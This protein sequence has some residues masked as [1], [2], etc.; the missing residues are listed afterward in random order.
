MMLIILF[1]SVILAG[2]ISEIFKRRIEKLKEFIISFSVS[3]VITLICIHI[4]PEI[5]SENNIEI[6]YYILAGFLVQIL[7][8]LLSKG[9]EHGHIHVHGKIT[10]HQLLV[11]FIGLSIHSFIE[12]LPVNTIEHLHHNHNLHNNNIEY[13][14]NFSWIYLLMILIHKLPIAAVLIFFLNSYGLNK[15]KKYGLLFIFAATAPLGAILGEE[16]LKFSFFND[17]SIKF[18]AISSGMLLHITTLLIFEDHHHSNKKIKN[19]I[20][21]SIGIITGSL[22]FSF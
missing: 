22:L 1:T 18:L 14:N 3:I 2:F 19:L 12:G 9:I 7:L 13:I 8:E 16:L 6:G 21:I 4:L 11:I 20:T 10:N 17:W 5:F 15:V